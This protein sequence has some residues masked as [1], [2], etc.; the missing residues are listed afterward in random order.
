MITTVPLA[1]H[2]KEVKR[3]GSYVIFIAGNG[4]EIFSSFLFFTHTHH[5]MEVKASGLS[6]MKL[7]VS[8]HLSSVS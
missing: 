4:Q 3:S 7:I 1:G 8:A 5:L 6:Y 2:L